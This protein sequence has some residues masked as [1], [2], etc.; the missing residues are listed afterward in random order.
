MIKD[1][2]SLKSIIKELKK[3]GKKTVF[4]NGC[5]DIIHLGHIKLLKEAKSYGDILI[6]GL[7]SDSSVKKIKGEK[8]P[9]MKEKERAI[10]LDSIKYVD[11][12]V[13]FEEETPLRLIKE[14]EPDV[15]VKGSDYKLDQI[16][17]ADFVLKKGGEVKIVELEEGKSTTSVIKKILELYGKS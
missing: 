12:V 14:L 7:N 1:L 11:F 15:L 3:Q 17:G 4:T 6:V 9:V 2:H 5:F 10:I 13:I 8:R 16:V